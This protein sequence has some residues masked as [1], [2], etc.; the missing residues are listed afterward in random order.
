MKTKVLLV[1]DDLSVIAALSG[2]LRSEGYDV[3]QAFDGHDAI[4]RFHTVAGADI[5]LLDLNMPRKGGWDTFE[6]LTTIN[7][8]LPVIIITAQPDQHPTAL[9]AGVS[10]L[11]EKPLE[12][13]FLLATMKQLL[14]EPPQARLNRIAGRSS[15]LCSLEAGKTPLEV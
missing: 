15:Y 4:D 12:I 14:A 3:I 1:D 8:L 2:V 9:A 6:R 5:A 7:P 11:M 10:A 13:P